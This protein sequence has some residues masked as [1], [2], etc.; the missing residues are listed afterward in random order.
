MYSL[1]KGLQ[2]NAIDNSNYQL[3]QDKD[4]PKTEVV[5]LF[6]KEIVKRKER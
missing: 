3:T 1:I 4:N 2:Q 5:N 6:N